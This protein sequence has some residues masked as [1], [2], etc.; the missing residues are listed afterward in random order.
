MCEEVAR[1]NECMDK[2]MNEQMKHR[3]DTCAAQYSPGAD[4]DFDLAL[5]D[6]PLP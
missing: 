3:D 5:L 4:G 1:R 6:P 2:C